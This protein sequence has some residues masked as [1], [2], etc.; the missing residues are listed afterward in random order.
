MFRNSLTLPST[1]V[2]QNAQVRKAHR[3]ECPAARKILFVTAPGRSS[4]HEG[5]VAIGRRGAPDGL[6]FARRRPGYVPPLPRNAAHGAKMVGVTAE[7]Q[8][9][10]L[11]LAQLSKTRRRSG[12]GGKSFWQ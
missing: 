12:E 5:G 7:L 1:A 6:P 3:L 9:S 11:A 10:T 8:A 2:L 4:T